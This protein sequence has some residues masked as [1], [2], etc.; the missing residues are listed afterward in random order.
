[1][2]SSMTAPTLSITKIASAIV[3]VLGLI[4]VFGSWY[5]VDQTEVAVVLRNG[6]I[7]SNEKA[8]LHFKAP[9]I[10]TVHKVDMQTHTSRYGYDK[11]PMEAYSADQQPANLSVA[12]TYHVDPGKASEM[13]S[14]F[15][16]DYDAAISRLITPQVFGQIKT[17]FGQYTAAKAISDRGKLNIAA[18]TSLRDALAYDPLFVIDAVQIENISFSPEYI[19]SVEARMQA[20]VEVER[21]KQNLEQE[22]VKA[23]IATTQATAQAASQLAIATAQAQ[24]V[25]LKGDA[26]AS[27]I[28]AK[29][30]ALGQNPNLVTLIQAERWNGA[31]P[32]TM[33]PGSAVPFMSVK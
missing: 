30:K 7:V 33:V 14:R 23:T 12:V 28:E 25:K 24:A 5:T 29:A 3:G 32:S 27:A 6:A 26:E 19:K 11:S 20:E 15:G 21:Q 31:L 17:V 2:K 10:E 4:V 16:G 22:K 9:W 1:M 8:G 13:Y 18:A